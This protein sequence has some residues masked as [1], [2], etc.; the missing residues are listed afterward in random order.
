[1][2]PGPERLKKDNPSLSLLFSELGRHDVQITAYAGRSSLLRR[3]DV[4]HFHW[5]E[6]L[7]RW[8]TIRSATFDI[9][10]SLGL[11]WLAR[12]RGA[13]VVWTGHDLEPHELTQPRLWRIFQ[14]FFISQVDLL[15]SSGGGATEML[16]ERYPQLARVPVT[17]VPHGHYRGYYRLRPNSMT[18]RDQLQLDQ[19]PVLLYFGQIRPYKN[20]PALVRAWKQLPEPRPQLVVAGRPVEPELESAIRSEAD[21]AKD[22]RLLLDFISDDDVAALF[23]IADVLLMPYSARSAL[24]SGVA[25]L[26]L[27]LGKPAVLYDTA[28]NR[29]LQSVFGGDWIYL[30]GGTP[31][32]ALRVALQTVGDLREDMPDISAIDYVQLSAQMRKAYSDAVESRRCRKR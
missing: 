5:P 1:M 9:L 16:M 27:S 13:A 2:C 4:I 11:L 8:R 22:V 28:V 15:V 17:V 31:E 29:D 19:R 14:S 23:A 32:D 6:W 18:F 7:I 3:R 21:G 20:V 24:N 12:R 25:H 30:C 26:A 10:T